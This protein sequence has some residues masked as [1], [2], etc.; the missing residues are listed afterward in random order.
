MKDNDYIL[1]IKDASGVGKTKEDLIGC[2]EDL[3]DMIK[4]NML[5]PQFEIKKAGGV[6]K[7]SSNLYY[8]KK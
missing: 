3:I 8:L 2:L 6:L 5:G 4:G 7:G 1:N